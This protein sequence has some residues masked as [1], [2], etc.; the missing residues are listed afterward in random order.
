MKAKDLRVLI[1]DDSMLIRKKMTGA[2][3][4]A[5]VESIY[6][7]DN[8]QTAV[9][10]CLEVEP[11]LVFM[12]IVMPDKDGLTALAEIKEIN[13]EIKVIMASSV[14]TQAY[15]K[16]AIQ[17]GAYDFIQKPIDEETLRNLIQKYLREREE[18]H[19]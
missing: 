8:G 14:G 18:S 6:E 11:H 7:A 19:V 10:K 3:K 5:G 2:L 9:D 12:D 17:L 1:C 4:N 15:L 13:K 16:K